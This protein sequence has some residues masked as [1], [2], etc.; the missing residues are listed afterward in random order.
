MVYVYATRSK[1]NK[2]I[3]KSLSVLQIEE[4]LKDLGMDLKGI[5]KDKDPELKIELTAEKMDM[6]SAVGIARAIKFYRGLQKE[7][8]IYKIKK[9]TKKIVCE[10]SKEKFQRRA[11]G[12]ILRNIPMSQEFLD[13]IIAIQ[14]KIHDSYGRGRKKISIGIYS[15]D[16]IQFPLKYGSLDPKKIKFIPLGMDTELDGNQILEEHEA[17]KKYGHLL[18]EYAKYPVWWDAKGNILSMPPVINSET[19]GRVEAGDRDLFIDM[20]G[21]NMQLLDNMLKVLVTT[22]IDLG[23]EAE[24]IKIE[25][26]KEVYELKL[27]EIKD[28][29]DI[30]FVNKIIGMN[31]TPEQAAPLLQ[32]MMY[33]VNS[34]KGSKIKVSIPSYRSDIW[35]DLD[36]ADDIA[37]GYGYNNIVPRFPTIASSGTRLP[38]S[39][40][41]D[42]MTG[43]MVALG[44]TELY[45]FMLSSSENQFDKMSTTPGNYIRISGSVD[46]G[47]NMVRT[48]IL[49]EHLTALNFNRKHKYPQKIFENGFTIQ[50]DVTAETGARNQPTLSCSIA[51]PHAN[52][53]QI[54]EV[55]DT[56][57]SLHSLKISVKPSSHS[58]LIPGRQADVYAGKQLIG[59]IGELHPEVLDKSGLLVPVSSFELRVDTARQ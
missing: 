13:E 45:T 50:E 58:F 25:Y 9:A 42:S 7:L 53:T 6:I 32:K 36:I 47:I 38:L 30:N 41:R 14:E 1:L 57:G 39:R 19:V 49:P 22:F 31:I 12:A 5:S 18:S 37:R 20:T 34:T 27:D 51:G 3:G 8:P 21:P 46:Q 17:G 59:W 23:A 54:K 24:A 16:K 35:H 40:F 26:G 4:T 15:L 11:V 55:L 29:I 2:L 52:Y 10:P 43:T 48:M 33:R 56:I 44:F 28:E